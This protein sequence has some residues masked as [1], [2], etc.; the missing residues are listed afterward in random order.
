MDQKSNSEML[1][2]LI[3]IMIKQLK[4]EMIYYQLYLNMMKQLQNSI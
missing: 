3:V 4:L 2:S 1:I